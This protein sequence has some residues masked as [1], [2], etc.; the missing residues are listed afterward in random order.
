MGFPGGSVVKNLPTNTADA[1]SIPG[2]RRSPGKGNG[3]QLQYFCL[4]NPMD[5]GAWWATVHR[6]MKEWVAKQQQQRQ[7]LPL[8]APVPVQCLEP[9]RCLICVCW[10]NLKN[11]KPLRQFGNNIE[12]CRT[13]QAPTI[14]KSALSLKWW[15]SLVV[16]WLRLLAGELRC[17]LPPGVAP[18]IKG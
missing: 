14:S 6:V 9:S 13:A 12:Q 18:S 10:V 17:C 7:E 4:G 8:T 15:T 2:C 16:H 3:N 1:G 5:S 11:Y